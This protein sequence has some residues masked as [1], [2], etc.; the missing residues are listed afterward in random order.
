V[1]SCNNHISKKWGRRG[2]DHMVNEFTTTFALSTIVQLYRGGQFYLWKKS[3]YPEKITGLSQVIEKLYQIM[4]YRVH[5]AM[6]GIRTHNV[7]GDRHWVENP[8]TKE[9]RPRRP[10]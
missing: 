3:E 7:S 1:D 5:L 10:R 6:K 9:S 8:N 2:R 4:L